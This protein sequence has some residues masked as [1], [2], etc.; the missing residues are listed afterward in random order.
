M[1]ETVSGVPAPGA[2][3]PAQARRIFVGLM[4][5][6]LAAALNLTIVAPALPR[7]VAELGGMDHYSWIALSAA[8]ASAVIVPAVGKLGDLYGRKPFYVGGLVLFMTAS[9][10]S[11]TAQSFWWLIGARILQGFGMGMLMP[12]SQAIVGDIAPPRERGKYQGLIGTAFGVA[13]VSGPPLGGW[14]AQ[15]L[16]WR[17][18]F[19]MNLPVG[20][21]ALIF[22]VRFM[23]LP[24]VRREHRL[25]Y[26]GFITLTIG[27]AAALLATSWGGT[28]YPWGSAPILGLYGFGGAMLALFVYLQGRAEEPVLPLYL[29][30]NRVFA[31]SCA[32]SMALA[33]GMFGAIYFVPVFAQGVLGV[34]IARSGI[35]LVPMDVALILV[36]AANGFLISK[37]G[38]YKPQMLMGLPL[39]GAGFILMRSL[40]VGGS[41]GLL[42]LGMV[43]VGMGIGSA[44]HTYTVVVQS[45]VPHRDL[46]VATS[47]VQF[48][49]NVGNTVGVALL[50]TIMTANMKAQIPRYLP[51]QSS[52]E[53]AAWADRLASPEGVA[54]LFDPV[55]LAT[56]PPEVA[57]GVRE[58]LA[59]AFKP[60]FGTAIVFTALAFTATA[61]L[62]AI[63][64]R[65]GPAPA[66]RAAEAA[67]GERA[68]GEAVSAGPGVSPG[69]GST[70]SDGGTP[71]PGPQRGRPA[72][73]GGPGSQ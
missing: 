17:W 29:W 49:R 23:H 64:L 13:A 10:L 24:H 39:M 52:P 18:L 53:A 58:G 25:D 60:I 33:M 32:A 28:Q 12:L 14:I 1:D 59:A 11:G 65:S 67:G 27:L 22:I 62:R 15:N 51:A 66:A 36:S 72:L 2:V 35:V 30:R 57:V 38:R 73:E 7:I 4:L 26:P 56:L 69:D 42:L 34:S 54:A 61:F 71:G 44:M 48:F 68:G 6:M 31:L 45:A 9:A 20:I 50:G 37:T 41:Y 46:G 63:P 21:I 40:G 55:R 3:P 16:S 19:F 5:G 70:V 43:L 47:A 8:L